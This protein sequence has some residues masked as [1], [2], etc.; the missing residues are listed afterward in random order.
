M[1]EAVQKREH[2]DLSEM[3]GLLHEW[4]LK[5]VNGLEYLQSR[6]WHAE[7]KAGLDGE[8]TLEFSDARVEAKSGS[9]RT[10]KFR[11]REDSTPRLSVSLFW[12]SVK[13]DTADES[14][15]GAVIDEFKNLFYEPVMMTQCLTEGKAHYNGIEIVTITESEQGNLIRDFQILDDMAIHC[16]S[17]FD[18]KQ[19]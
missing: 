18:P 11:F 1:I 12:K 8:Q 14:N 15:T 2:F 17:R 13:G 6:G 4:G 3:S 19:E 9:Q 5:H 7:L 16:S 10:I